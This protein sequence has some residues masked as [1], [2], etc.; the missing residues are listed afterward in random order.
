LRCA[1]CILQKFVGNMDVGTQTRKLPILVRGSA[2]PVLVPILELTS[3]LF[4][5]AFYLV[6][7]ANSHANT[8]IVPFESRLCWYWHTAYANTGTG[9]PVPVRS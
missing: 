7:A 1:M 2:I 5:I 8:G 6:W 4:L 9:M 3:V